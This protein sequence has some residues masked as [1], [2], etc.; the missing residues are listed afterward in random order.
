MRIVEFAA[1]SLSIGLT[2]AFALAQSVDI[3]L[4]Y[5]VNTGYNYGGHIANPVLI[6]TINVGVN[7]GPALPYAFDTGSSVFLTPNGLFTGGTATIPSVESYGSPAGNSFGG[8][9]YQIAASSLQYYAAPGATSGGISLSTSG[10][11]NVAS[12][13][14]LNGGA[15]PAHP[16]GTAAVGVFGASGLGFTKNVSGGVIGLGGVFG[17]TILPNT[18]A[19]YVVSAN[20]QS[21]AALNAMLGTAIP[22]GPVAGAQQSIQTVP[23]SVTSC[24]PCVT[25]GLTPALL[26]QFLPVN[27]VSAVGNGVSF[28]NS[29]TPGINKFVPFN[30]T[31]SSPGNIQQFTQSVSLDTGWTDFALSQSS[32]SAGTMLTMS[33]KNGGTQATFDIAMAPGEPSPY[34]TSSSSSG[35][36]GTGFFVQ[37]SVLYDLAGQQV[38]YSP[39]FVT[40]ANVSTTQPLV[41]DSSSVP[42]GL[43]GVISGPGGIAVGAGGS[44]TL[45]G[46]NTYTG[47]TSISGAG[48]YLA[49]VGPGTIATSSEVAVSSGGVFDIS[50]AGST[51]TIKSL[52]GDSNGIV[53]LGANSLALS[54]AAGVFAGTL[55]GWGGLELISGTETLSGTNAYFGATI[56]NGGA[57]QVLGSINGTSGVTVNSGGAL[58][59]T[60]TIDSATTTIMG[61]GILAPGNGT[62]GTSIAIAGNLAFQSGAIYLVQADP[63]TASFANV[64]GTATLGGATVN[65]IFTNGSSISKQYTILTASGGVSGAFAPVV[66]TNLPT[67]FQTSLSYDANHAYLD[68]LL[69]YAAPG[70]STATAPPS[71]MP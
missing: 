58:T 15:L 22:G 53:W 5:T 51:A 17:Q 39:N 45:S 25:V 46:S 55:I 14:S 36:I 32:N 23:Q 69:N 28:P 26:A 49:L 30:F 62:P 59:G 67:N 6:L 21:L 61:G 48:A 18:T 56:V 9:I 68:L 31:L 3:P 41:I 52:S 66:N 33:A 38:A 12:Y 19:G 4:N 13:T 70:S 8:N 7:G 42:L 11:Y 40:D 47:P 37:N 63:T 60:G 65:A 50:N 16:F 24:N 57:L 34:H 27:T 29:N 71:A 1:L 20:G 43:A 64:T 35:F 10:A 54:N 2:P 44:A